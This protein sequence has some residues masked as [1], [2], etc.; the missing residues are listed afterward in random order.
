MMELRQASPDHSPAEYP[1]QSACSR[2]VNDGL[3]LL[4]APHRG[5]QRIVCECSRPTCV[6]LLEITRSDY[7]R[8]RVHATRFLMVPGHELT[9]VQRLVA[10]VNGVAVIQEHQESVLAQ[11]AAANGRAAHNGGFRVLVVDDEPLHRELWSIS[12]RFAGLEVL[13]EP[14]GLRGLARARSECPNLVLTDVVM[15]RLDGL[16][17]AEGLGRSAKTR[18]IP[19]IFITSES[20][21][22]AADRAFELG[23][24]AYVAKPCDPQAL[25]SLVANVLV[26]FARDEQAPSA[27][28]ESTLDFIRQVSGTSSQMSQQEYA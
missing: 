24:V 21:P 17:L 16:E 22:D 14:D 2:T 15:P 23:A 12:L 5:A 9:S 3:V 28:L 10:Q 18:H 8:V 1:M 20:S 27:A 26:R 6:E 19:L 13:E 4:S 11:P 7:D 25:A